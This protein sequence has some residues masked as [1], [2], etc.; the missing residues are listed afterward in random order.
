MVEQ[1]EILSLDL[2]YEGLRL[3]SAGSERQLLVSISQYGIRDPLQ[4]VDTK[5]GRVLLDGFKRLRC[6]KKLCIGLVP[7]NSLGSDE[8]LAIIELMRISNAKNLS[9][10]EQAKLID[11]LKSVHKMSNSEIAGHLE[12]SKAWVSVRAGIIAEMSECVMKKI[13]NGDFP[14]YAY[15]YTLRQFIRINRISKADIDEFVTAVSGKNLSIRDIETLA[16]GYFKGS[17]DFREQVKNGNISWSL[18]RL[19]DRS[20][21]ATDCTEIERSMLKNL[22]IVQKYMQRVISRSS[23]TRYKSNSFFAQANL[24]SGG[25]LRQLEIFA[26]AVRDFHDR[27]RQT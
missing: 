10:L 25:I 15:M 21:N 23:D 17:Q 27:S 6:A 1:V 11:E 9:I 3:K 14:V 13:F 26:K 7:Y 24:I 12:K 16:H 2:R 20:A 18:S 5:A 22:E 4:G 8:A 19:K